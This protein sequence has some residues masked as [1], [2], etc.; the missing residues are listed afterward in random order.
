MFFSGFTIDRQHHYKNICFRVPFHGNLSTLLWMACGDWQSTDNTLTHVNY[1]L[2]LRRK[3]VSCRIGW[4]LTLRKEKVM[5]ILPLSV[6]SRSSKF[7]NKPNIDFS[8][9]TFTCEM[10]K[11][12]MWD[13]D[14]SVTSRELAE[15]KFPT[16]SSCSQSH[17][18]SIKMMQN[19]TFVRYFYLWCLRLLQEISLHIRL[20]LFAMKA[21]F[22]QTVLFVFMKLN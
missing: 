22:T 5:W 13:F 4:K 20:Y 9:F 2:W 10:N 17:E 15:I 11:F 16:A 6:S 7:L 12:H 14:W 18:K 19:I 1:I 21:L 3:N 8:V